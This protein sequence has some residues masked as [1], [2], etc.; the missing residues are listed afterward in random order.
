MTV[1]HSTSEP[2]KVTVVDT[3]LNTMTGERVKRVRDCIGNEPFMLTY[4]DDMLDLDITEPLRFHQSHGKLVTM[5]AYNAGQRFGVLDIGSR[6]P[7]IDKTRTLLGYQ[8]EVLVEQGVRYFLEYV[9]ES[10]EEELIW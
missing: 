10:R 7:V 2:W 3:G 9:K 5:S 4:G 8:P 6:C 1:H